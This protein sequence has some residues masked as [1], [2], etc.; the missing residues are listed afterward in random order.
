MLLPALIALMPLVA[1]GLAR[2]GKALQ[3]ADWL[4][5]PTRR[6]T[7]GA[8]AALGLVIGL[9]VYLALGIIAASIIFASCGE[10]PTIEPPSGPAA[11]EGARA[12][13]DA[14]FHT[15]TTLVENMHA[16]ATVQALDRLAEQP[17]AAFPIQAEPAPAEAPPEVII[18]RT[19]DKQFG[20]MAINQ[21]DEQF[22]AMTQTDDDGNILAVTGGVWNSPTGDTIVF[23][24]GEDGLPARAVISEYAFLY[25]DWGDDSVDITLILP[26][27][28]TADFASVPVDADLI[29][30]IRAQSEPGGGRVA[31]LAY[32]TTCENV[33]EVI[34]YVEKIVTTTACIATF[35]T[36]SIPT[37][38]S[39]G[40]L[41]MCAAETITVPVTLETVSYYACETGTPSLAANES[42]PPFELK[43][44]DSARRS[45]GNAEETL[46]SRGV[47]PEPVPYG[48][49]FTRPDRFDDDRRQREEKNTGALA[50]LA[51]LLAAASG[52]LFAVINV[53]KLASGPA[54]N[55]LRLPGLTRATKC[56]IVQLLNSSLR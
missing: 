41:D 23:F 18:G 27:G 26:D 8:I 21:R 35:A 33:I 40:A 6:W 38:G 3:G 52:L 9:D 11:T 50:G 4:P 10:A 32:Q 46:E 28:S 34:Q 7:A 37:L 47:E 51:G 42:S 56:Y 44:L 19:G 1:A 22:V 14:R 48:G 54:P 39:G 55:A 29:S 30:S 5:L 13:L 20:A 16:T 49:A 43:V 36:S 15:G 31:A 12:T 17:Q 2:L 45:V 24:N 53:R 25:N